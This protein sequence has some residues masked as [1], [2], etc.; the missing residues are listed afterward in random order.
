MKALANV[1]N[2]NLSTDPEGF[3]GALSRPDAPSDQAISADFRVE[4]TDHALAPVPVAG[5]PVSG[6]AQTWQGAF[7]VTARIEP[8][9][10]NECTTDATRASAELKAL[11]GY[12]VYDA[13]LIDPGA[14]MRKSTRFN[15]VVLAGLACLATDAGAQLDVA[16]SEPNILLL[17]DNSGSMEWKSSS[18]TDPIC[19]PLNPNTA[20]SATNEKSRW[21]ELVEALTGTINNYSCYAEPRN[22]ASGF[23]DEYE[24]SPTDPP[25]ATSAIARRITVR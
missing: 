6:T 12:V 14:I 25:Y 3:F 22:V 1:A 16:P 10:A 13:Q 18:N 5:M 19:D 8:L 9:A 15:W 2:T 4:M 21:T 11:R 17:V 20:T 24:L 7:T 23:R